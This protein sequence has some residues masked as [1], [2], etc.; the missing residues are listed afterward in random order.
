MIEKEAL[1]TYTLVKSRSNHKLFQHFDKKLTGSNTIIGNSICAQFI[2]SFPK[3]SSA[4]DYVIK[5]EIP[6]PVSGAC[7]LARFKADFL[8]VGAHFGRPSLASA[9]LAEI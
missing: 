3:E 6:V 7:S 2:A 5:E 4:A 9:A 8:R 1:S